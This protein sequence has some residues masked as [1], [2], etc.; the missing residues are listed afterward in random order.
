MNNSQAIF[1]RVTRITGLQRR[2]YYVRK[3]QQNPCE[4]G[5]SHKD[6]PA[7]PFKAHGPVSWRREVICLFMKIYEFPSNRYLA[8]HVI[9]VTMGEH[10]FG[11]E[12]RKAFFHK[13]SRP[14]RWLREIT[15]YGYFDLLLF[16][17]LTLPYGVLF[18]ESISRHAA[19]SP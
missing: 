13:Y 14:E 7:H 4:P 18:L 17:L 16:V 2:K 19:M 8:L 9:H 12:P 5:Q 15:S 3:E 1:E 6:L 10:C 11:Q